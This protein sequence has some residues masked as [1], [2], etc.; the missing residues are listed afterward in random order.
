M[1]DEIR[2]ALF[3]LADRIEEANGKPISVDTAAAHAL[4][5]ALAQKPTPAAPDGWQ[6]VPV[7]RI[8]TALEAVQNAMLDAYSNA[9]Q[10]CCGRGQY[11]CCGDPDV[12]WSAED[13]CIMSALSPAQRELSALLT[14]AP[15]APIVREPAAWALIDRDGLVRLLHKTEEASRSAAARWA[16]SYSGC[17]HVPLYT[18][19]DRERLAAQQ[20][21]DTLRAEVEQLRKDAE[22]YRW[23]RNLD[24]TCR[25]EEGDTEV[26]NHPKFLDEAVDEAIAKAKEG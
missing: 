25:W 14:A 3:A 21:R 2:K 24:A 4:R 11:E 9:Y 1:N 23:L 16:E 10:E 18:A 26:R 20:E 19:C 12:A 5:A 6:L 8:H 7:E 15:A 17:L 22:R 13:Q